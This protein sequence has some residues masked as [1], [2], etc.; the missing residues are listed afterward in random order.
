MNTPTPTDLL[1][2]ST[3]S[4]C[5]RWPYFN[6][7]LFPQAICLHPNRP[8]GDCASANPFLT[9]GSA[10]PSAAWV[11]RN[12]HTLHSGAYAVAIP[13][14][15]SPTCLE[16]VSCCGSHRTMKSVAIELFNSRTRWVEPTPIWGT[17]PGNY[18]MVSSKH[19]TG[20]VIPA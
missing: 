19:Y 13:A 6:C 8:A 12:R 18:D 10:R 1:L 3:S 15:C 20:S 11:K 7:R 4:P 9:D 17:C 14:L 2:T 5:G 16:V